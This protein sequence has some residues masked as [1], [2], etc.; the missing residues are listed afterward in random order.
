MTLVVLQNEF[1][2]KILISIQL[3]RVLSNVTLS[4]FLKITSENS[5]AETIVNINFI[6]TPSEFSDFVVQNG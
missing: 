6:K 1:I 5:V 3:V 2:Y 4:E